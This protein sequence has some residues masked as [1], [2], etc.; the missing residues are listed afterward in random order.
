MAKC[1]H[2]NKVIDLDDWWKKQNFE[3][4]VTNPE[5][6]ISYICLHCNKK[7]HANISYKIENVE[8]DKD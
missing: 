7:F 4:L 8:I 1:P 2:C 5:C 3:G 6:K